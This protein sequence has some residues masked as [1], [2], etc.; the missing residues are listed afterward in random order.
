MDLYLKFDDPEY[1]EMVKE[2]LD[3]L[4]KECCTNY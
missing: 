4:P 3:G 2:L 1:A